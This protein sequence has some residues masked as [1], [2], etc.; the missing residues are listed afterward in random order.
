MVINATNSSSTVNS[1]AQNL[2]FGIGDRG[3]RDENP[4]TLEND[5]GKMHRIHDDGRIPE[6]NPCINTPGAR[7]SIYSYG[8]RNPRGAAMH[9]G[10]GVIWETEHGPKVGDELNRIEK[11]KN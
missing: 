10:T 8:H 11:G 6:D 3:N 4:Q 7:P 5:A 2:W 9:P 1:R